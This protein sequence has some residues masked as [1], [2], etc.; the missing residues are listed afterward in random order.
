MGQSYRF[1]VFCIRLFCDLWQTNRQSK[2]D[3]HSVMLVQ[4][5]LFPLPSSKLSTEESQVQKK[6]KAIGD[7]PHP[8]VGFFSFFCWPSSSSSSCSPSAVTAAYWCGV[9][10]LVRAIDRDWDVVIPND[11]SRRRR[12][13][14]ETSCCII[15]L[16]SIFSLSFYTYTVYI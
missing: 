8:G 7:C 6:A 14:T 4:I 9:R 12:E 10:T 13:K 3:S 5:F 2:K 1:L 16:R 11:K 15:N